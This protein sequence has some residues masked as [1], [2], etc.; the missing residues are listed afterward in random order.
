MR[1][2]QH[3]RTDPNVQISHIRLLPQVNR[4]I[5]QQVG[6][7]DLIGV[8]GFTLLVSAL[9]QQLPLRQTLLF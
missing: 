1:I 2:A 7:P 6:L 4:Q 3:P 5:A 8:L 9:D